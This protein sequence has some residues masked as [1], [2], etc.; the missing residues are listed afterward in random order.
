MPGLIVVGTQYGDEGKGKIVDF[1]GEC[2]SYVVRYQGGNNAGHTVVVD[3]KTYKFHL[4]PAGALRDKK[5]LIG[6][7]VALDPRQLAK[8][9]DNSGKKVDLGIDPRT[10]IILP[11]HNILDGARE[12]RMRNKSGSEIGTTNKGIGPC[13]EDEKSR[14]GLRFFDLVGNEKKLEKM[15]RERFE[16][17]MIILKEVHNIEP[18]LLVEEVVKEYIALGKK[19]HPYMADVSKKVFA[20]LKN[21]EKIIFEGAQGTLLDIAFG[22]YPKV[23][24]SHPMSG[25]ILTGIGLPPTIFQDFKFR[26]IGVVKAYTTKVGS[27]PVITCLDHNKW[28]VDENVSEKEAKIIRKNGGEVGTTTGRPRRVGWLDTVL[29]NYS[30]S[31]NSCKE[32]AL[33]KIDVL[34]GIHPL[35]IAVAY[36]HNGKILKDYPSWD[37]EKL[38]EC[39]AVYEEIDGFENFEAKKYADLPKSVKRYIE[40]IEDATKT[41]ITIIS[42]SAERKDTIFKNFKKI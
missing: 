36:K 14:I 29:L 42:T 12:N 24:S 19:L 27:G 39:E 8:E 13:Y 7:G 28:P 22:N 30:Q 17:K 6:C 1:L 18:Q 4:M 20:A 15:I 32:F 37:L 10:P 5:C 11:Y 16:E 21:D 2:A 40:I 41:P 25:A 9:I 35:K 3:G 31:L 26:I 33:T 34:A 38:S 23:T